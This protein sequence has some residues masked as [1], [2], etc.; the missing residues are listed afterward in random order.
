MV[1]QLDRDRLLLECMYL[2]LKFAPFQTDQTI[3]QRILLFFFYVLAGYFD[4]VRPM[5]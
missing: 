5:A 2:M 4:Q 1:T 3:R